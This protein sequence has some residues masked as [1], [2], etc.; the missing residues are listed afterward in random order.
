M[1][2][3]Y[4]SWQ[5]GPDEMGVLAPERPAPITSRDD[6]NPWG[7]GRPVR[8]V[9]GMVVCPSGA[10]LHAIVPDRH[11]SGRTGPARTCVRLP[12]RVLGKRPSAAHCGLSSLMILIHSR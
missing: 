4:F 2:I 8:F 10:S 7:R 5:L 1:F 11:E 6:L 12:R 9:A 3:L